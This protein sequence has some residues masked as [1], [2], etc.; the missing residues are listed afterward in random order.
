MGTLPRHARV[1]QL[2]ERRRPG[3][4]WGGDTGFGGRAW[5]EFARPPAAI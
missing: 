1:A 2:A 5:P 4:L 3:C